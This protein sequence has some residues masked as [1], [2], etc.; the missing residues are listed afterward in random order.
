MIGWR[1]VGARLKR[2]WKDWLEGGWSETE[3]RLE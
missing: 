2:G 1:E 3:E